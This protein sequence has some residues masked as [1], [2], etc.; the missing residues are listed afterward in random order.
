MLI[1]AHYTRWLLYPAVFGLLVWIFNWL[2]VDLD[3]D[4]K[5]SSWPMMTY[6]VFVLIWGLLFLQSWKRKSQSLALRWNILDNDVVDQPRLHAAR[7][8]SVNRTMKLAVSATATL[9]L[10]IALVQVVVWSIE[11]SRSWSGI[12][13]LGLMDAGN[14]PT[15]CYAVFV[16]AIFPVRLCD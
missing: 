3:G 15:I 14:I 5:T 11:Y 13:I 6:Y 4:S 10:T 2:D 8:S 1:T 16:Y 7:H 12:S 9:L